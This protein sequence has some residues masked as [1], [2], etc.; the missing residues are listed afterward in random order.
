MNIEQML[1]DAIESKTAKILKEEYGIELSKEFA[2]KLSKDDQDKDPN[3]QVTLLDSGD[4]YEDVIDFITSILMIEPSYANALVDHAPSV[5]KTGLCKE[6]AIDINKDLL[7]LGASSSVEKVVSIDVMGCG[8]NLQ[9][10]KSTTLR[11]EEVSYNA[12]VINR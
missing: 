2:D 10:K 6:A 11:N 5:I 1:R 8:T 4:G 12:D 3:Y 7:K 9:N